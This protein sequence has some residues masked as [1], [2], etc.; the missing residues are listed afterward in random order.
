MRSRVPQQLDH[1]QRRRF[2]RIRDV[3]LVRHAEHEDLRS[4][5]R[6]LSPVVQG[7][8]DQRAAVVGHVLVDLA[9]ELDELRVE[10]VFPRLPRE[11]E[12]VDRDAV[13]AEPGTG[14]EAHEAER[15]R[16][17]R[18]HDLP[19]VDVHPVAELGELVDER[20]V[21]RAEDVLE[22]LRQLGGLRRRHPVYLVD[23]ALVELG[24]PLGAGVG[25]PA[26]DLRHALRAPARVP[27]VH[28]L[29]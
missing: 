10:A 6:P 18:V 8:R 25:D 21:D 17:R 7:L 9:G 22:Q 28:A 12:R 2:A 13:A 24:R 15:L 1:L 14:L 5:E 3:W 16:R 4:L 27:G 19:H 23:R 26:D 11:V 29:G 20:D